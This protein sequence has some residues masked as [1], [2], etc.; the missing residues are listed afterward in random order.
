MKNI[1]NIY[2]LLPE[3]IEE[4]INKIVEALEELK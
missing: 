3:E 1:E 2:G 4:L